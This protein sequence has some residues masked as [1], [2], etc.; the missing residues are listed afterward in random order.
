MSHKPAALVLCLTVRQTEDMVRHLVAPLP[1]FV[2]QP[3]LV[4]SGQVRIWHV[5]VNHLLHSVCL[6]LGL[7]A[8]RA[9]H[10]DT[11]QHCYGDTAVGNAPTSTTKG[12]RARGRQHGGERHD[13]QA[14]AVRT[15]MRTSETVQRPHLKVADGHFM[16]GCALVHGEQRRGLNSSRAPNTA[17]GRATSELHGDVRCE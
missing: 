9:N 13:K 1:L 3:L 4:T 6:L 12:A 2:C 5:L 17:R 7:Q 8:S 10:F 15:S 16:T 14:G 11:L